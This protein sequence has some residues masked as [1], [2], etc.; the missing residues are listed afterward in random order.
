MALLFSS[1]TK[2]IKHLLFAKS[3]LTTNYSSNNPSFLGI[4]HYVC[5]NS[6]SFGSNSSHFR[7]F[8][9]TKA[10]ELKLDSSYSS[11]DDDLDYTSLEVYFYFFIHA[12]LFYYFVNLESRISPAA[13]SFISFG[14]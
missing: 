12:I 4:A 6:S 10:V 1:R 11:E 3:S 9:S 8:E 2:I 14:I 7:R 5:N 13:T